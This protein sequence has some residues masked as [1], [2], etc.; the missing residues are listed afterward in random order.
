M[1]KRLNCLMILIVFALNLLFPILSIAKENVDQIIYINNENDLFDFATRVNNGEDFDGCTVELKNDLKLNCSEL[2]QWI[3]IG[4][5]D[6]PFKGTFNGNNHKISGM[7]IYEQSEYVGL[8]GYI[9]KGKI[10]NL[11]I[12]NSVIKIATDETTTCYI[13]IIT[14]ILGD[15]SIINCSTN[16]CELEINTNK[17]CYIGGFT[18]VSAGGK[19]N[20]GVTGITGTSTIENNYNN[21]KITID[22]SAQKRNYIGGIVGYMSYT[23]TKNSYNT[24]EITINAF[25]SATGGIAGENYGT[26]KNCCNS[27]NITTVGSS[28]YNSVGTGGIT[29]SNHSIVESTYNTGNITGASYVGG[30]TGTNFDTSNNVSNSYNTGIISGN[31]Y[32]GGIVGRN[33]STSNIY[34][35]GANIKN[36]YNIGN[37]ISKSNTVGNIVGYN[38]EQGSLINCYYLENELSAYGI[39]NST[40]NNTTYEKSEYDMKQKEFEVL[41]NDDDNC[42]RFDE[43][44]YNKGYPILVWAVEIEIEQYPDKLTYEMDK[45]DLNLIGGK[46]RVKNNY[47]NYDFILDLENENIDVTGFEN[48]TLGIKTLDV[49]YKEEL[50]TTFDIEI[51]DKPLILTTTYSTKEMTKETVTVTIN[52][53]KKIQQVE[54]WTLDD[55]NNTLSKVYA[56]NTEETITVYDLAGR[57]AKANI[58]I[59]NIDTNSPQAEIN[60]ST[61]KLTNKNVM[62]TVI[63]DE[64]I[65]EVEGW[66][67]SNDKTVLTKEFESN[68]EESITIYDLVGNGRKLTINVNNIDKTP[69]TAEISYNTVELTNEN[70]EVTITANEEI[71]EINGWIISPD[72]KKLVKEYEDNIDKEKITISDL[73]GNSAEK[74]I[75]ITNIDKIPPELEITYSVVEETNGTVIVKIKANEKV[76]KV[77]GWTLNEEQ[78]MLTKAFNENSTE[79]IIVYDLV[80][81]GTVQEI[82]INNITNKNV[83]AQIEDKTVAPTILPQTGEDFII[84]CIGVFTTTLLSMIMYKKYKNYKDIK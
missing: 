54:D 40:E 31:S 78:N 17:E 37:I 13:G 56:K 76:K 71:Q 63:A 75:T 49:V 44:N 34:C 62:V 21:T 50:T 46:I 60:Y 12:E 1:L 24:A 10:K 41:L 47:S 15:S 70:V 65:K 64:K 83:L 74:E 7:E 2:N 51:V 81:N 16:N 42:Y 8:F 82:N 5:Y 20:H 11:I 23:D 61:T 3:P 14:G 43:H 67:L 28:N 68:Q 80:G 27:G 55:E 53:N 59:N 9:F 52:S 4:T 73:A 84:I 18:G 33:G 29:G 58:I 30:I 77:E 22:N 79:Q 32:I 72:R 35:H 25:N 45:E 6:N 19:Y 66:S 38:N 26:I 69:P 36:C 48:T 57:E 39:N